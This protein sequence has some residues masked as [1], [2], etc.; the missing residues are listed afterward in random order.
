MGSESVAPSVVTDPATDVTDSSATL[1]GRVTDLGDAEA[2]DLRFE[3]RTVGADAWSTTEARRVTAETSWSE[4]VEGLVGETEHEYRAVAASDAGTETD[5]T[6]SFVTDAVEIGEPT[7][8][9][10]RLADTSRPN[11]HVD[12]EVEWSVSH[13]DD[14]LEGVR[15]VVRNDT[16]RLVDDT[17]VDVDGPSASGVEAFRI[18]H[19]AG[20]TY[21]VTLT[22]GDQAGNVT[23][24]DATIST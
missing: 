3:Y 23:E 6:R 11:P 13:P 22:V 10:L 20:E 2:V 12:L 19:G 18:K 24:E 17:T 15:I 16:D 1:N 8:E 7:I 21:V 4:M 9:R 5:E 14:A